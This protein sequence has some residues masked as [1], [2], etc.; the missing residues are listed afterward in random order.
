MEQKFIIW[1]AKDGKPRFDEDGN[2]TSDGL[3]GRVTGNNAYI[4]IY[5]EYLDNELTFDINHTPKLEIGEFTKAKFSLSGTKGYYQ[6]WRV[7]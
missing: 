4:K 2:I 5:A 1:D 7:Q 6:V 3:I